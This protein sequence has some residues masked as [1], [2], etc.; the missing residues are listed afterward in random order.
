MGGKSDE[1][2]S[3]LPDEGGLERTLLDL[4]GRPSR[5]LLLALALHLFLMETNVV[6]LVELFVRVVSDHGCLLIDRAENLST[7][8]RDFFL[9]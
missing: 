9:C 1:G 3:V 5:E 4:V 7:L 8:P 6:L 2:A